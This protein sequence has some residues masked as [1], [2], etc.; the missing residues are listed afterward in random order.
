MGTV[1]SRGRRGPP[2]AGTVVRCRVRMG[3]DVRMGAEVDA[4]Q[5]T[6]EDRKRH[7]QKVRR[8]LDALRQ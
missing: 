1:L 3:Q 7:R 8:G 2:A 4:T 5:F 6:R